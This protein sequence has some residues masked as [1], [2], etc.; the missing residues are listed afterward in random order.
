MTTIHSLAM[1]YDA[2]EEMESA[3]GATQRL[4]N[5]I[6]ALDKA[7]EPAGQRDAAQNTA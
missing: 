3:Y 5:L 1:A 7:G 2:L 6:T 4:V